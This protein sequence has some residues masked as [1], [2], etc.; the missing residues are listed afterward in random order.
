[1]VAGG[2]RN[3]GDEK[4]KRSR[5]ASELASRPVSARRLKSAS[6]KRV[7]LVWLWTWWDTYPAREYGEITAS[8]TRKPSRSN[9]LCEGSGRQAVG[10]GTWSKKPPPS[11]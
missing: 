2:V 3:G 11:S 10:G 7:T 4:S 8:G 6:M 1:M 5:S 9:S